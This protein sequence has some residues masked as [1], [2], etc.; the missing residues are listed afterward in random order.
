MFFLD[1][2][3]V[4]YR[5]KSALKKL[6]AANADH[7]A[8]AIRP[9]L[10]TADAPMNEERTTIFSNV[11]DYV[12]D[13]DEQSNMLYKELGPYRFVRPFSLKE[14]SKKVVQTFVEAIE[15]ICAMDEQQDPQLAAKLLVI[16]EAVGRGEKIE[17][18]VNLLIK[19]V[20]LRIQP[21]HQ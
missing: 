2:M 8:S 19:Q 15:L 6:E 14:D 11:K 18:P 13:V 7:A 17:D 5:L 3:E 16:V 1:R 10:N 21:E 20:M 12:N 4:H 9:I